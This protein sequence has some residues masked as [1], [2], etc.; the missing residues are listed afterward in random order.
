MFHPRGG[1]QPSDNGQMKLARDQ[2][3]LFEIK[4][5]RKAAEGQIYHL[6]GFSG[7]EQLLRKG[8]AVVQIIDTAKR[9][10]HS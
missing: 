8:D 9:N 3:I 4:L 7:P 5:A 2:S 10:Y 6:G 1:G